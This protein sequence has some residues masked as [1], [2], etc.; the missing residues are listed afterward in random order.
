MAGLETIKNDREEEAGSS[1]SRKPDGAKNRIIDLLLIT[2]A[3]IVISPIGSH[4][5]ASL[6]GSDVAI[7]RNS[8]YRFCLAQ[9]EGDR[10]VLQPGVVIG[11]KVSKSPDKLLKFFGGIPERVQQ[12]WR[13]W[14]MDVESSKTTELTAAEFY[15]WIENVWKARTGA[16]SRE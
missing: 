16:G 1:N 2:V 3:V 11:K 5:I 15:V 10:C 13:V 14:I 4:I 12:K 8:S 9:A 6:L 7:N